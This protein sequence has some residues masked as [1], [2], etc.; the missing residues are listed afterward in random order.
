MR[1]TTER[2]RKII[3]DE[4]MRLYEEIDFNEKQEVTPQNNDGREYIKKLLA[5][6]EEAVLI[7][8]FIIELE[9][10]TGRPRTL[11]DEDKKDIYYLRNTG[12]SLRYISNLYHIS[13]TYVAKILKDYK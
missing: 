5:Q 1:T 7:R 3:D 10:K 6:Y 13:H 12:K 9:D 11:S 2:I 8:D 4:I